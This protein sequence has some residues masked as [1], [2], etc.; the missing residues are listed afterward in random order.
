[1]GLTVCG[2]A[3][4]QCSFGAAPSSLMVLPENRVTTSMPIAN[5]MDKVAFVNV[6]PN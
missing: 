6:L 1:M 4:L 3:S 2:G 5:I